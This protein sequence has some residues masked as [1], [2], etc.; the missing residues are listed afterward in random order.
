MDFARIDC[1]PDDLQ[2]FHFNLIKFGSGFFPPSAKKKKKTAHG[3]MVALAPHV[4]LL[5]KIKRKI[6][7]R[8]KEGRGTQAVWSSSSSSEEMRQR[9]PPVSCLA[10]CTTVSNLF[11]RRPCHV[12]VRG[13]VT[14]IFGDIVLPDDDCKLASPERERISRQGG[15]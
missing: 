4:N 2:F 6:S 9:R 15:L 1:R 10:A 14:V 12:P 11:C 13:A 3:R 7:R 8:K 5:G